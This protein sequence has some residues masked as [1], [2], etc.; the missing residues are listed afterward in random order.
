MRAL[1]RLILEQVRG[2]AGGWTVRPEVRR[3]NGRA[4]V[5]RAHHLVAG[6]VRLAAAAVAVCAASLAGLTVAAP[7]PPAHAATCGVFRWP[8]KTGSDADRW[9]VSTTIRYTSVGYL[10]SLRRPSGVTSSYATNHRLNWVEKHTWQVTATLIAVKAEDDGDY[11]LR[12]RESGHYMVAEV[13][14]PSCV[15]SWSRWKTQV[16]AARNWVNARYPVSLYG[17]H[18][19]YRTVTVRGLGFFDE[20]HNVTGAA[21]NQV[22]LHPVIRI[23]Y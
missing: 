9:Q 1:T 21:P 12:L 14:R 5:S 19:V 22:E 8:V 7:A 4:Q 23:A 11:H 3:A 6:R 15:P 20:E 16:S 17:W 13:P 2:N 18:Y 10:D